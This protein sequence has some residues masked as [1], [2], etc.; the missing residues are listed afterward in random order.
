MDRHIAML[1]NHLCDIFAKPFL[2]F[3]LPQEDVLRS[4]RESP[5][6][7]IPPA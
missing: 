6:I 5:F 7:S 2:L 3:Y 1:D 4:Y